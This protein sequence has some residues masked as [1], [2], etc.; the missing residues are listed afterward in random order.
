MIAIILY[1]LICTVYVQHS[2]TNTEHIKDFDPNLVIFI[3][4]PM[5]YKAFSEHTTYHSVHHTY[6]EC[7][8]VDKS[9]CHIFTW[10]LWFCFPKV[11]GAV[12][13]IQ[14]LRIYMKQRSV[15][16]YFYIVTD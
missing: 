7:N 4:L 15:R 3:S 14:R 9:A 6:I 1:N 13:S 16:S 10:Q 8:D 5:C 11:W 2:I 12:N